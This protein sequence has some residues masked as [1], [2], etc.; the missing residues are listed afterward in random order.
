MAERIQF[1]LITVKEDIGSYEENVL[2]MIG[3]IFIL[4]ERHIGNGGQS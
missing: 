1:H 4:Q 2:G 3:R